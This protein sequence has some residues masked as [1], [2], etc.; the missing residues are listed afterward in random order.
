M[1]LLFLS[2]IILMINGSF[3]SPSNVSC[4]NMERNKCLSCK[5]KESG[6]CVMFVFTSLQEDEEEEEDDEDNTL[7]QTAVKLDETYV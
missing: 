5:N 1:E 7:Y 4:Q 3:C 2:V 6:L